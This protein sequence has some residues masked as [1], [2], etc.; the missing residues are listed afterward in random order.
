MSDKNQSIRSRIQETKNLLTALHK[1]SSSYQA[2]NSHS[3][4]LRAESGFALSC[5]R[6]R[7]RIASLSSCRDNQSQK[8]ERRSLILT[9][10]KILHDK[11]KGLKN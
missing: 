6:I 10:I 7:V 9:K 5:E 3:S 2:P 8:E 11:V 4:E 1:R